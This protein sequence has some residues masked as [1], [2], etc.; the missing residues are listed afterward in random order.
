[1]SSTSRLQPIELKKL[2]EERLQIAWSTGQIGT[3]TW[4]KLREACPCALCAEERSRPPNP[5]RVLKES[6]I[7]RGP[8]KAIA[9]TPVGRYAYK[10]TWSDGH[11]TGLF[12]FDLL[13]RLCEWPAAT[14]HGESKQ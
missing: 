3:I 1:M 13:H 6:E 10:I 9:V 14:F 2:G 5:L 11:D 8:L 4:L 7:P 12:T